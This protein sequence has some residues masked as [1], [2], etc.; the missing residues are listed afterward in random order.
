MR[1]ELYEDRFFLPLL[2]ARVRLADQ[3][4]PRDP[5]EALKKYESVRA[6]YPER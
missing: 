4:L 6:A 1:P 3:E 5:A 2:W